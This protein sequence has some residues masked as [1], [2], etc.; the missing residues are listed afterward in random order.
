MRCAKLFRV[1]CSK[2]RYLIRLIGRIANLYRNC[3]DIYSGMRSIEEMIMLKSKFLLMRFVAVLGSTL[4]GL[5]FAISA[6]AANPES[7]V[8][9]VEFFAPISITEQQQLRFGLIDV[10][11]FSAA[12]TVTINTD[13]SFLDP[14][15]NVV[16]GVKTAADMEVTAAAGKAITIL[17]DNIS[18]NTGYTVGSFICDYAGNGD[19]ACDGA[20]PLSE[21][22]AAT[23]E[24][25]VGATITYAATPIAGQFFGSFDITITYD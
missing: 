11:T 4:I 16:G 7:V 2:S 21:T 23:A 13:S 9:E 12:E 18:S 5:M 22:S 3:T 6:S 19:G 8:V 15:L 25:L 14:N 24:L 10:V 17:V 20:G 1:L